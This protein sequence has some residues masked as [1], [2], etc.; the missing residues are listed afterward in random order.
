MKEGHYYDDKAF[1]YQQFW[2]DRQYEHLAEVE[3]LVKFLRKVRQS[4][5]KDP[6]RVLDIG[7]G[8]GRL[9]SSYLFLADQAVLLEPSV[10][11]RKKAKKRLKKFSNFEIEGKTI[12]EAQFPDH[13]F[14]LIVMIRVLH[15]LASSQKA[16]KKIN[17]WLTPGGY[18]ILEFPNKL[19]FGNFLRNLKKGSLK[20]FYSLEAEDRR[21]LEN[22]S[23]DGIPFLNFH[24]RWIKE[25]LR[26]EGFLIV[27]WISVSNWRSPRL[28]KLLP[29]PVLI[30]LERLTRRFLSL[31]SYGPSFFVLAKKEA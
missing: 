19:N 24:P 9:S 13:S 30:I 2:K 14:N 20:G 5:H 31:F 10:V 1:D 12:E 15:H 28:K 16:I 25:A 4:I 23:K 8:Y 26:Q 29:S 18:L 6:L 27:N 21:S 7:A 3:V 22:I 17:R 11:L